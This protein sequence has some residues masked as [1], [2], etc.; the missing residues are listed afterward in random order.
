L[1]SY[2]GIVKIVTARWLF[3][4]CLNKTLQ[5]TTWSLC[6]LASSVLDNP[7]QPDMIISY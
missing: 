3:L 5:V 1:L 2:G 6:S 4:L 7:T